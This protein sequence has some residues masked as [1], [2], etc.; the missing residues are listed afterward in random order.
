MNQWEVVKQLAE[1]QVK[2]PGHWYFSPHIPKIK[3]DA[4]FLPHPFPWFQGWVWI[5]DAWLL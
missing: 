3:E 2:M 5:A 1:A 4:P